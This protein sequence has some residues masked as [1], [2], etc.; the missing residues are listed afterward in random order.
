MKASLPI[1]VNPFNFTSSFSG[2][3]VV[4]KFQE[5]LNSVSAPNVKYC[6][7]SSTDSTD[8]ATKVTMPFFGSSG[9]AKI[10][11]F[12][13]SNLA[14]TM[15]LFVLSSILMFG[16]SCDNTRFK[17]QVPSPSYSNGQGPLVFVKEQSV[18][19]IFTLSTAPAMS[20]LNVGNS[21][22][23]KNIV[24]NLGSIFFHVGWKFGSLN[25]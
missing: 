24:L 5:S 7:V 12:S 25:F 13:T 9:Q 18:P 16:N 21:E 20:S 19:A 4:I 11:I 23:E 10:S 2:S 8:F 3:N 22:D 14:G 17:L 15:N 1:D 6:G